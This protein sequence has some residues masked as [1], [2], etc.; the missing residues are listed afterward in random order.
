MLA[1]RDRNIPTFI[2]EGRK[3]VGQFD[4]GE[5]QKLRGYLDTLQTLEDNRDTW[6]SIANRFVGL[7]D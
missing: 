5:D 1:R 3:F 7:R 6:V 2:A 4:Q